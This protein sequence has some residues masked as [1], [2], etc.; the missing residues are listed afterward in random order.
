M[1]V[2]TK[3]KIK[4]VAGKEPERYPR[5]E[6]WFFL[7]LNDLEGNFIDELKVLQAQYTLPVYGDIPY[8]Y[9]VGTYYLGNKEKNFYGD[10]F[11]YMEKFLNE[12]GYEIEE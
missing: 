5:Y 9:V 4:L 11:K 1:V 7:L 8:T 3:L 10:P 6:I 2:G 12:C